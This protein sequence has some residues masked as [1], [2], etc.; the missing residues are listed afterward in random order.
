MSANSCL[1]V[2]LARLEVEAAPNA[3]LARL[4]GLRL[5][6]PGSELRYRFLPGFRAL[7][8]LPVRWDPAS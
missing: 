1:G 5:D 2:P 4:P 7:E 3:L 6:V 8:A